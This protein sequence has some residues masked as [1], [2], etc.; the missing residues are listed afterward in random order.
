MSDNVGRLKRFFNFYGVR[1]KAKSLFWN[2]YYRRLRDPKFKL[3]SENE[4]QV[5]SAIVEDELHRNGFEVKPFLID[6]ADYYNFLN[7][8]QYRRF[9]GYHKGGK[10]WGF[11]EKSLEHYLAAKLLNL[12]NQ[13]VFLDIACANSPAS[14]IYHELYGCQVY[15]QDQIFPKG[16]HGNVIGGNAEEMP[17]PCGFATKMALHCSF[18]H[19]ERNSDI[20]FIKEANRVL[21]EKG[22]LCIVPLYLSTSYTIFTDPICVPKNLPFES[23]ATLCCVKKWQNRHGR[24]YDVRHL[25]NRIRDNLGALTLKIFIVQNEKDV[26]SSCYVKFIALLEKE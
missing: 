15:R 18:E 26:D 4:F 21:R 5:Q 2:H 14:F 13:D 25:I 6:K 19:F 7:V 9:R 8:A 1:Y 10:S 11:T 24:F 20:E 17:V 16:I 3:D 23:D 12:S 22:M